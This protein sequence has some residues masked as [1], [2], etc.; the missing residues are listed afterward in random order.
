[1]TGVQTCALPISVEYAFDANTT[2]ADPG[3]G[4]VRLNAFSDDG[5]DYMAIDDNDINAVN[6][7]NYLA[8]IDD[9][10]S[11]IKG[12]VKISLKSNPNVF[13]L[14]AIN[15]MVDH[16]G[17]FQISISELSY[18]GQIA[19]ENDVLITF[20]RT[21]D[22]GAQGTQGLQGET[23]IQGFDGTQGLQGET[24]TQGVQGETGTQGTQGV[25]GE[26][27]SQ[28]TQGTQGL[29]GDHGTQGTQ[30]TQ[31]LQGE[32]GTQ[33]LQGEQGTQGLQGETGAQGTQGLQGETGAQGAQ[34]EQGIQGLQ[35]TDG[36]QGTA[37]A[38]GD[39]YSTTSS[40]SFALSNNGSQTIYVNDL[41][42]DYSTGQDI[43]V[44]YDVSNIQ[45]RK[46]TRLN[47]SHIPLSRMPSSA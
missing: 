28:G 38:D 2:M 5:A 4:N 12:H 9:S 39:K 26:T 47:S 22:V 40:T 15:S 1:M 14:Y 36:S 24:G 35:G 7:S 30:G 23:G 8:T 21:G 25:Q 44:A 11:T 43:T 34:G 46:S 19:D 27:G 42:V 6:I 41:N 31:G 20:A 16:S 10:T 37:G 3:S 32:T 33:G 17:W 13:T 29:Q 18:N 45:D